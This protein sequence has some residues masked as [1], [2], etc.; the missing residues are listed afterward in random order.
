M[1]GRPALVL[2]GAGKMGG[3]MLEGWLAGGMAGDSIVVL[4]PLPGAALSDLAR[5]SG[6]RINPPAADLASPDILV[7]A[8]KPQ[9]LDSAAATL[10]ALAGPDTLVVSIIA[11]KTV[12]DLAARMPRA[13][14]F[15]RAM[16]NTP[17]AVGRG[18][19]GCAASPAVTTEQRRQADRLLAAVG[20]VVWLDSEAQIDAVTA[21]SGSGPAYVFHLVEAMT[22]AGIALGLAPE[23]AAQLARATIEGAGELLYRDRDTSPAQLRV[24]VTSPGGTTAAALAVL[25]APDGMT[26]LMKRAIAAAHRR[27]GELSG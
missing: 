20:S 12:A 1:N 22:E 16:P 13:R 26:A 9:M 14:A 2:V 21:V 5:R 24:N 18:I 4:D 11:G 17:A 27:A 7:L 23:T 10:A 8:V 3:A 15:V 25:M 6:I 19:A